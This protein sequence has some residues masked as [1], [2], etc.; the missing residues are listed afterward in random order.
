[1]WSQAWPVV[2]WI[3]RTQL[4]LTLPIALLAGPLAGWTKAGWVGAGGLA[5]MFLTLVFALRA[6]SVSAE[7]DAKAALGAMVRAEAMKMV[8][9]V[10]GF[11]LAAMTVPEHFGAIM[12]GFG[13]ATISYWLAL[14]FA[15]R[16]GTDEN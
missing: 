12:I 9:A 14:P 3:L 11:V 10:I 8:L 5:T 7:V 6:F 15:A 1:M 16:V 4:A 13:A 2:R